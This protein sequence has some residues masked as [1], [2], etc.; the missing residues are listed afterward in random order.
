M[1]LLGVYFTAGAIIYAS[2][3]AIQIMYVASKL[4]LE[5]A[6]THDYRDNAG[7]ATSFVELVIGVYL[8]IGGRWVLEKVLTP[9]LPRPSDD[10]G[11]GDEEP[12][13]DLPEATDPNNAD[14][15]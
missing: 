3:F 5:E 9:V 4:G 14:T 10:I 15:E 12:S 11:D 6:L 7:L 13:G 2:G 8:L 1:R